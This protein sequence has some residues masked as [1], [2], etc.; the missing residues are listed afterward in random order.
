MKFLSLLRDL[1]ETPTASTKKKAGKR[2]TDK[3]D[4]QLVDEKNELQE[5]LAKL[6]NEKEVSLDTETTDVSPMKAELVGIG[7]CVEPGEAVYVPCNGKLGIKTHPLL[8]EFFASTA[9]SFY[10]QNIKY[11]WHVLKNLGME[12]RKISFDTLIAS[13]LLNPH[14]RRHDLDELVLQKFNKH[15][16]PISDLIGK[17]KDQISMRDVE[18]AKITE[19]CCEDADYTARLKELFEEELEEKKLERLFKEIELPLLPILAKM[20]RI[21]I[22]LDQEKIKKLG[23]NLVYDLEKLRAKIFAEVGVEF[24]LNSPKQL[25]EILFVKLGL[26]QPF[27]KKTAFSTGADVLEALAE[28]NPIARLILE[29]RGLE[30]LRSTYIEALPEAIL[31]RT[32]RIHCTFS[33]SVAATGRLSCQDPNLQNIPVRSKEGLAIRGC[34]MPEDPNWS[35]LGADYSQIEL[36]ILA[37][38][39][40]DP[41]LLTAFRSGQDIHTHTASLVYEIPPARVTSEMRDLAKVVNFGIIYGQSAFGLS[42]QLGI[43]MREASD[44]IQKYFERYPKVQEYLEFCKSYARKN[45][46]AVTLTGRQ[47]PIPEIDSKNPH[48]RSAAERLAVNTPLQGTAADLIKIAMIEIDSEIEKRRLKG[49][50]ILQIHDELIFEIPDAE[51]PVFEKLVKEKMEGVLELS[52]PIEVHLAI[53]KNWA[54]C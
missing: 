52:V 47:R 9:C 22:F 20:E 33:Q 31:P 54:E 37:H 2:N 15:K 16:I 13:Y 48:I 25:S 4:Y 24:N 42:R 51:V 29:Y 19:Y 43:S 23:I 12:L 53:G 45:G 26:K 6:S 39:S 35:Y 7:F 36:R 14:I 8:K 27:R 30:K 17:G 18:I 46:V 34:F 40:Q 38:F 11:D 49:K 10:G 44:F 41:E 1:G 5:L 32:G 50:M 3:R 21:G 28:E